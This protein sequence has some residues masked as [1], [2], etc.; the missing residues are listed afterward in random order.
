MLQD[1]LDSF[2]AVMES[3]LPATHVRMSKTQSL[4]QTCRGKLFNF[5]FSSRVT[6]SLRHPKS[7]LKKDV[8]QKIYSIN[9]IPMFNEFYIR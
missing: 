5:F 7:V 9:F 2:K 6:D 4:R 1:L 8:F 3:P